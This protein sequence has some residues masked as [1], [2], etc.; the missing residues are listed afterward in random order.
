M[1]INPSTR[2]HQSRRVGVPGVGEPPFLTGHPFKGKKERAH[3]ADTRELRPHIRNYRR[4]G[5]E[6]YRSC[7]ENIKDNRVGSG[8]WSFGWDYYAEERQGNVV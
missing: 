7:G 8:V 2:V 4:F 1:S 6:L 5:N 3:V